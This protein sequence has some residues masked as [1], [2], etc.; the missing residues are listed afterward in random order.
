MDV[1]SGR[2]WNP[3]GLFLRHCLRSSVSRLRA[4]DRDIARG[5]YAL[6]KPRTR[7]LYTTILLVFLL[8]IRG[9]FEWYDFNTVGNPCSN[10]LRALTQPMPDTETW[11]KSIQALQ[12]G[13]FSIQMSAA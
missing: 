11:I 3:K 13:P 12:E 10:A 8:I 1:V 7:N 5:A 2:A 9:S 4:T 6:P